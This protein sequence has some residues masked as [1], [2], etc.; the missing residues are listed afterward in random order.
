MSEP[1]VNH[2]DR[3]FQLWA[4]TVS[5]RRLL[6]RSTK[7]EDSKTRVDVLFQNVQAMNLP[8]T[9]GELVVRLADEADSDAISTAT[10][11]TPADDVSFYT[12][13][14]SMQGGYVVASE[15]AEREDEGEYFEPSELWPGPDGIDRSF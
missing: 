13:H 11:V 12:L 4:Y 14:G 1:L 2:P 6:F 8:K 3:K 5:L 9:T 10:G 15:V 7:D